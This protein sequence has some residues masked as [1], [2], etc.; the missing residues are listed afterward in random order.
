MRVLLDTNI[1][2]YCENKKVTNYSVG[3]LF[4]WIDKL[5]KQVI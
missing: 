1:I 3:H 2:I 4:R 5:K